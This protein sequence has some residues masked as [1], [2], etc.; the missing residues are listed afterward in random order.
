MQTLQL[1]CATISSRSETQTVVRQSLDVSADA[2]TVSDL[3]FDI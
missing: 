3:E 1:H 2:N